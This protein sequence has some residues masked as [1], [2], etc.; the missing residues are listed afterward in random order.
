MQSKLEIIA[1]K[2]LDNSWESHEEYL[3][4]VEEMETF[5]EMLKKWDPELLAEYKW[6]SDFYVERFEKEDRELHELEQDDLMWD[7]MEQDYQDNFGEHI[8][9]TPL[10]PLEAD[11]EWAAELNPLDVYTEEELADLDRDF[12]LTLAPKH[13]DDGYEDWWLEQEIMKDEDFDAALEA[14]QMGFNDLNIEDFDFEESPGNSEIWEN[15]Q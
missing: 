13:S 1:R 7:L 12:S 8:P 15:G 11:A 10:A 5:T 14:E 4:T 9:L 6:L 2:M 3:A